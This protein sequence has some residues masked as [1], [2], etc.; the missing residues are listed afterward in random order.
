VGCS[1]VTMRKKPLTLRQLW[2]AKRVSEQLSQ[3]EY[4]STQQAQSTIPSTKKQ[5]RLARII[6]IYTP[7]QRKGRLYPR[8][9]GKLPRAWIISGGRIESKR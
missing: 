6:R 5:R 3:P 2:I 7:T 1:V 8:W 9:Q 4:Q